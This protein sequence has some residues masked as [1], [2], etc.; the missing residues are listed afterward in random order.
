M[1]IADLAPLLLDLR[2]LSGPASFHRACLLDA[3]IFEIAVDFQ[4]AL[5]GLEVP[6][7]MVTR[8]SFSI[9][10][11]SFRR[12]SICSVSCSQT[13]GVKSIGRIEYRNIALV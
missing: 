9:W 3:G 7:L 13:F 11:R 5:L 6:S 10:F 8:A 2:Q 4:G 1:L 12:S